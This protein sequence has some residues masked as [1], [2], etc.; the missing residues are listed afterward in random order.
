MQNIHPLRCCTEDVWSGASVSGCGH[1]TEDLN[2]THVEHKALALDLHSFL[3]QGGGHLWLHI[4]SGQHSPSTGLTT[5]SWNGGQ[6]RGGGQE[7]L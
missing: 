6:T 7:I 5:S 4:C 3:V 1:T 2:R